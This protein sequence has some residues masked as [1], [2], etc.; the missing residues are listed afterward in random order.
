MKILYLV[1]YY[2]P[3]V[4][5][6]SYI[7]DNIREAYIDSGNDIVLYTPTPTRGISRSTR[8]QYKSKKYEEEY[9]G[10]LK[11]YRFSMFHEGKNPLIRAFRYL[12]CNIAHLYKGILSKDVDIIITGSTPPTQGIIASILKKIKKVPFIY[13]LQDIFPDSLESAGL[14][15]KGSL[16]WK[17]GRTIENYTYKN[18]DR[19]IVISEDFK[20]NIIEKGVPKE[21][22]EV[23][24]NW[25]DENKVIPIDRSENFI[26]DKY[27]LNREKFYI[28]YAGNLGH[29]QNI[30]VI[31]KT[32]ERLKRYDDIMF[33][34]FGEG[35]QENY[36]KKMA[37]N[38]ELGNVLFAPLEPYELVSNVYSLGD[39]SIVSCKPGLGKS[40]MPSKTWS[41]MS[42]GT[43]VIAN[44]DK[45]T[46]LQKIIEENEVGLFTEAGDVE[47]FEKAVLE[48]YGNPNLCKKMGLNGREYILSNLTRKIGTQKYISVIDKVR[49]KMYVQ[50]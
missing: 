10:K 16:L 38:N 49:G 4:A 27:N 22:I 50:K 46:D 18:A 43:A 47:T 41:I 39:V 6:S 23:I 34:I 32:A 26:F 19:I 33:V 2:F 17:L 11:I 31:L 15:S 29:A 20:K 48:L 9:N 42:A 13:Y 37:F 36:Y 24:Y 12:C 14:T 21:K 44:F 7:F 28:V 30:E 40:V 45:D 3:E 8:R 5:A 1:N 35:H 25:V